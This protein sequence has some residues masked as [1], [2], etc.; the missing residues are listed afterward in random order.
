[1]KYAE[2]S[3]QLCPTSGDWHSVHFFDEVNCCVG[4]QG[5]LRIIWKPR[6]HHCSDYIQEQLNR[7]EERKWKTSYIWTA[8]RY[9]F[10]SDIHFYK[11]PGNKNGKLSLQV[12]LNQILDPV[13]KPWLKSTQ[14]D[15]ILKEDNNSGHV[16]SSAS[17]IVAKRKKQNGLR[18]FFN[19]TNSPD[20]APIKNCW[21]VMKEHLKKYP[22]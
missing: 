15:L 1:V 22:H 6:E 8:V 7:E 21:P 18:S 13:V 17:N 3:L 10:K 11:T 2:A 5:K 4:L 9:N 12:Y 16:E 14:P 20:L 19:C